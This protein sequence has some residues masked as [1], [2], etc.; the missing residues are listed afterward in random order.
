MASLAT[1]SSVLGKKNARHLLRRATFVYTKSL[2]D[3]YA[4]LTPTQA[5]D[6]LFQEKP[7]AVN[8]PYD[9]SL[10]NGVEA[11]FWTETVPVINYTNENVKSRIVAGWWWYNAINS[12]NLKFKLSYFLSTRFTVNKEDAVGKRSTSFFHHLRLLLHYSFGNYKTL[13]KKMS[14]DNSMLYYLNNNTNT[15]TAPN[16]NYARE[17][18]ELFTIGKGPQVGPGDYTNYTENDIVEAAKVLTGFRQKTD[19]YVN[20]P[21]TNIP[22]GYYDFTRHDVT[23]KRFSAAFDSASIS[24]ATNATDMDRELNDFVEMIFNKQATALNICRKLY[25]Y[26]VKGTITSEVETDIIIPLATELK[27]NNYE[28]APTVRRLLQS[29]HFYDLD[30]SD[31]N[32]ETIGGIIKSPIQQVSEICTYLSATIPNPNTNPNDYYIRFWNGFVHNTYLTL[33]DMLIFSPENVAGHFAYYKAPE[34]DKNWISAATLIARYRLG[35]SMIEGKNLIN[36]NNNIYAKIDIIPV[37]KNSGIISDPSDAFTLT[38]ELCKA[39]F[40]QEP[41]TDRIN[42]FMNAYL[43]QDLATFY[44]KSAWTDYIN[45][46][47][48]KVIEPRLKALLTAIL[49]APETQIF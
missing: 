34:F 3:Q 25:I 46:G 39:L 32:D 33:S 5:L 37:I 9:T 35:E 36:A 45:T 1:N 8:L 13:A 7:L 11:G 17:F 29:L 41:D 21:D 24:P 26:F 48:I 12:P 18:L 40:A 49:R 10:Y 4:L 14:L 16:Q 47:N 44:W 2:V 38:S 15:K 42:Y 22:R 6:L 19:T 23:T 27:A 30:D 28:L 31:S 43:L 20:D